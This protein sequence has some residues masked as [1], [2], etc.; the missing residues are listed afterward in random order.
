MSLNGIDIASY[1][2]G[3][4][5]SVVP[6]DFAIVKATQ[7]TG[8]VNPDCS[9][10]VEQ[11]LALGKH[12]G[13]YHYVNGAGAEAES[14]Y[15]IRS[16][17]N[18][19]GKVILA[20]DW[21]QVQNAKWGDERYLREVVREVIN[22]SGVKPI[23][24]VQASKLSAVKPIATEFDCGLWVAQYAS[25]NATG[26]QSSPWNEGAYACTIRQYT[27]AG[28]LNGWGGS[29][30]LN[31]FYG[32]GNAWDAYAGG[33]NHVE[34]DD[35]DS[36]GVDYLTS[37]AQSV[38]AGNFGN[39]ADNRKKQLYHYLQDKVN[40]TV[41]G[42]AQTSVDSAFVSAIMLGE[43]GNGSARAQ[44]IYNAVQSRVNELL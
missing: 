16:T 15:F 39:G 29:L 33:G 8:Y 19:L 40:E 11:G 22:K 21:E 25:N 41:A 18:W 42:I 35:G 36:G 24:Y 4:D 6:C 43:Y 5:L 32:D 13:I 37:F 10:A 1:Q 23:I 34:Q 31:I 17:R 44:N 28:R 2:T 9:R 38:I 26:Y 14:E 7:G 12:M 3:L 20:L 27:S 30:D